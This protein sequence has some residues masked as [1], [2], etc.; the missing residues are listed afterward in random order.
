ME[1]ELAMLGDAGMWELVNAPFGANIVSPK[2]VFKAKNDAAGNVIQYKARL[3]AQGF[4]QVP[5]VDYFNMFAPVA[6]LSSIRTVLTIAAAQDLEIHQIDIK[7][8]Y[9]NGKLT[10]DKTIH[11]RQPPGFVDPMHPPP[12]LPF[13]EDIIWTQAVRTMRVPTSV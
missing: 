10:N 13:E 2:W 9:L 11:M 8:A 6:R 3:V 7:G 12:S 5:G 4:S 1:E